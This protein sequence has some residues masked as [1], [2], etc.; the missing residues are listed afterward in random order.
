[1]TLANIMGVNGGDD[2]PFAAGTEIKATL[3]DD[4]VLVDELI[5]GN[6]DGEFSTTLGFVA[7]DLAKFD[8][9]ELSANSGSFVVDEF[10]FFI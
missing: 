4:G 5:F 2:A 1:M 9:V 3:Y 7:E 6:I 10:T 8:E